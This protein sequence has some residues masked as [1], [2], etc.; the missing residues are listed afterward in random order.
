MKDLLS[1]TVRVIDEATGVFRRISREALMFSRT[2]KAVNRELASMGLGPANA[3]RLTQQAAL[4]MSRN[5]SSSQRQLQGVMNDTNNAFRLTQRTALDTGK[6]MKVIDAEYRTVSS[7]ILD[8]GNVSASFANTHK[9]STNSII[10]DVNKAENSFKRMY[11]SSQSMATSSAK[12]FGVTQKSAVDVNNSVGNLERRMQGYSN[13]IRNVSSNISSSFNTT[14]GSVRSSFNS[15]ERAVSSFGTV[16]TTKGV[17]SVRS[18]GTEFRNMGGFIKGGFIGG[19]RKA[20][21]AMSRFSRSAT[22]LRW[23]LMGMFGGVTLKH[24]KDWTIG[25]AITREKLVALTSS[26]MGSKKEGISFFTQMDRL[27]NNSLVDLDSLSQAM[28]DIRN[29]T[30]MSNDQLKKTVNLVNDIGQRAVLMGRRG[31]DL[32]NAMQGYG[33]T[34]AGATNSTLKTTFGITQKDIK[35]AGWSGNKKDIEGYNDALMTCLERSGKLRDM[36]KTTTGQIA[37]TEKNFRIAGRSI[38]NFFLPAIKGTLT[39]MNGL[40]KIF[41]GTYQGLIL[42][43]SAFSGLLFIAP[44]FNPIMSGLRSM[45]GEVDKVRT[46]FKGLTDLNLATKIS[47]VEGLNTKVAAFYKSVGEGNG[48]LASFNEV[49]GFSL[50]K[51]VAIGAALAILAYAI[52]KVGQQLGWWKDQFDVFDAFQA[53]IQRVWSAI[54]ND[55]DV[56]A[57]FSAIKGAVLQAKGAVKEL[58]KALAGLIPKDLKGNADLVGWAIRNL[59]GVV[60][61][62]VTWFIV[63]QGLL[64][65]QAAYNAITAFSFSGLITSL[66]G[67]SLAQIKATIAQWNL[68]AAMSANVIGLIALAIVGLIFALKWLYEN[69]E[70]FRNSV[71]ALGDYLKGGFLSAWNGIKGAI[72]SVGQA[73]EGIK[74]WCSDAG[75]A[76]TDFGQNVSTKF[77][78]GWERVKKVPEKVGQY[79]TSLYNKVRSILLRVVGFAVKQAKQFV[80]DPVKFIKQLPGKIYRII[81]TLA[82]KIRPGFA[83]A[84]ETAKNYAKKIL[85]KV[86]GTIKQIPGRIGKEF[87]KIPGAISGSVRSAINAAKNWAVR[88]KNAALAPFQF[89]S[90]GIIYRRVTGDFAGI[91]ETIKSYIPT[92]RAA[93]NDYAKSIVGGFGDPSIS[94][95]KLNKP[96]LKRDNYINTDNKGNLKAELALI[97]DFRNLPEDTVDDETLRQICYDMSHS[98]EFIQSLTHNIR[99]Q[100]SDLEV[101][102]LLDYRYKRS[103]GV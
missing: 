8:A 48:I 43:A 16:V 79:L 30:G 75:Q 18:L 94:L 14:M 33:R 35:N 84:L 60:K 23:V 4:D 13:T 9:S 25:L 46:A 99:F 21:G 51:F 98:Y 68:N 31:Q 45:K 40:N 97:L 47:E 15:A 59:G 28:I 58:E 37:I 82:G 72:E 52:Y 65:A 44:V 10:N 69:N 83:K 39:F 22:G 101:K 91:P 29:E 36:M 92:A 70:T 2:M 26:L 87:A 62:V 78:Q 93:A 50:I 74:Q 102:R 6:S 81:I 73:W 76:L 24:M 57:V 20:E 49:M 95:N 55:R 11:S 67:L 90:P 96:E 1:F 34:F 80:N 3:F 71:N 66:Q 17:G 5:V 89:G 88:V 54:K 12:S 56:K 64:K 63:W 100:E 38:G 19:L 7:R 32:I 41:P 86:I 61:F 77:I 42:L 103:N 85:N 53:G 27:T